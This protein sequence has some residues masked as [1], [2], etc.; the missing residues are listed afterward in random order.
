MVIKFRGV[1]IVFFIC[2]AKC[3]AI[4]F[5]GPSAIVEYR[6][7]LFSCIDLSLLNY[8]DVKVVLCLSGFYVWFSSLLF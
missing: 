5:T 2:K 3:K 4:E 1:S 6:L 7:V 8:S